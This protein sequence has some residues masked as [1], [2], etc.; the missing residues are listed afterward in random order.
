MNK[1]TTLKQITAGLKEYWM[2]KYQ[3]Y[4]KYN[5]TNRF[6]S[7]LKNTINEKIEILNNPS[8][9]YNNRNN[10]LSSWNE[11][12]KE[13]Y[14]AEV[15]VL[16]SLLNEVLEPEHETFTAKLNNK[17]VFCEWDKVYQYKLLKAGKASIKYQL[18]KEFD[19]WY[20]HKINNECVKPFIM[21]NTYTILSIA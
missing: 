3:D 12:T 2:I 19:N 20:N 10:N 17:N 11:F 21:D 6:I 15:E 9:Y 16:T 13:S 1:D 14:I 5:C 4:K 8:N 18:I 7:K